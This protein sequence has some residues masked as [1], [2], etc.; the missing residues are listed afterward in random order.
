MLREVIDRSWCG[1]G[2]GLCCLDFARDRINNPPGPH[3]KHW[4]SGT[5]LDG[6]RCSIIN[7]GEERWPLKRRKG[8]RIG[9]ERS[10]NSGRWRRRHKIGLIERRH[11]RQDERKR[12][13][14]RLG[15][16]GLLGIGGHYYPRL[17]SM[18]YYTNFGGDRAAI[19]KTQLRGPPKYGNDNAWNWSDPARTRSVN[20]YYGVTS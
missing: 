17:G 11:D 18:K 15:F 3:L 6:R 20:D 9:S 8:S 19:T 16:G 13:V 7:Q 1:Y 14:C 4:G 12:S 2:L 10:R 5:I